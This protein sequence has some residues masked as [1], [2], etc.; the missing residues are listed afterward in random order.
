MKFFCVVFPYDLLKSAKV[1]YR[2]LES[3]KKLGSKKILLLQCSDPGEVHTEIKD[4]ITKVYEGNLIQKKVLSAMGF[5]VEIRI[6]PG[7]LEDEANRIATLEDYSVI[8]VETPL[9]SLLGDVFFGGPAF[10]VVYH[11]VKPVL[12]VRIPCKGEE[13]WNANSLITFCFLPIFLIMQIEL[14]NS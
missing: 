3:M 11:A 8:V 5:N 6:V 1:Q 9:R 4:Y 12:L 14:L 13:E 7:F 10:E 2:Y